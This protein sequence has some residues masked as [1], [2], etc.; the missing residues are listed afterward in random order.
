MNNFQI[1]GVILKY[2]DYL[3]SAKRHKLACRT[4]LEKLD[5]FDVENVQNTKIVNLKLS[6][7]YLTGYIIECSLKF[8]I[9]EV[10]NFDSETDIT[11]EECDNAGINYNKKIKIHNFQKLQNYLESQISDLSY[12][13]DSNV[14]NDLLEKWDP[15]YRYEHIDIDVQD[16]RALYSHANSFLRK[17]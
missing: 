12:L 11:K 8:K 1:L 13:S 3:L 4:L 6:A 15:K 17:M 7:F 5:T 9:F 16:I 14:V 2:P 10:F